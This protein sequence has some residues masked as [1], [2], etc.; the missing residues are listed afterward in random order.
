MRPREAFAKRLE[1]RVREIVREELVAAGFGWPVDN[2]VDNPP[3]IA[4]VLGGRRG[5]SDSVV[6]IEESPR[7]E[8]PRYRSVDKIRGGQPRLSEL[9]LLRGYGLDPGRLGT[10]E[11]DNLEELEG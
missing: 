8:S 11:S 1:Q 7:S 5:G 4:P 9:E 6:G 10:L 3:K 2:P